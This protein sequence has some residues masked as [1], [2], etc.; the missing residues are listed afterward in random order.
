[1]PGLL[2]FVSENENVLTIAN[3]SIQDGRNSTVVERSH[4]GRR[5]QYSR[6]RRSGYGIHRSS[7][8]HYLTE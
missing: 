2:G 1:M 4:P 8:P 5:P 3:A 6:S 7:H